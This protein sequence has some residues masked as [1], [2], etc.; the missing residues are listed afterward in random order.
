MSRQP[1]GMVHAELTPKREADDTSLDQVFQMGSPIKLISPVKLDIN[2]LLDKFPSGSKENGHVPA[3][4]VKELVESFVGPGESFP[5]ISGATLS[6]L[7]NGG[8]PELQVTVLDCRYA[9]EFEG[10]HVADALHAPSFDKIKELISN[11]DGESR[12]FVLHCEYSVQ[13]APHLYV[14]LHVE[15]NPQRLKLIR[16]W[17]RQVNSAMYPRLSFPHLYVLDGGYYN[18]WMQHK[19]LCR[20][21]YVPM[22]DDRFRDVQKQERRVLGRVGSSNDAF[23]RARIM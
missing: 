8:K 4:A 1:S 5:R 18:F 14:T 3:V 17:D 11:M 15:T 20:G 19:E 6:H 2:G 13:R 10:G 9:Y 16:N 21:E 23:R 12:V 22:E 7:L